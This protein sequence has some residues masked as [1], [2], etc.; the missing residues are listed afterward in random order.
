MRSRDPYW[1]G[2]QHLPASAFAVVV[3][4]LIMIAVA[5]FWPSQPVEDAFVPERHA[6]LVFPF[7]GQEW[8]AV[9]VIR[10]VQAP[11]TTMARVDTEN[12]VGLYTPA[13]GGGG[14]GRQSQLFVRLDEGM[15]LPLTP[16]GRVSD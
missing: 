12:G 7:Q 6:S 8:V 15:Y 10:A 14:T 11:D 13:G 2:E 4:T 9:P 5:Q 16:R 3:V 1:Q